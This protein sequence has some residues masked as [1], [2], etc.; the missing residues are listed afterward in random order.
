MDSKLYIGNLS[1]SVTEDQL[2]DLFS[3]FGTVVEV[4]IITDRESGRSKGFAFVTLETA[5][6]A[7]EAIAKLHET[8]FEGRKLIV[9]IARP[10]TDRPSG[11]R[12]GNGSY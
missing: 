5:E 1:Y 6:Q 12:F 10:K 3:Q 9:S 4:S 2:R 11:N 7:Q 8:E